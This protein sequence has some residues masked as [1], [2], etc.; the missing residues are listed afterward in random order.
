MPALSRAAPHGAVPPL[1]PRRRDAPRRCCGRRE[2]WRT[3]AGA[4]AAGSGGRGA[5]RALQRRVGHLRGPVPAAADAGTVDGDGSGRSALGWTPAR[6]S[7]RDGRASPTSRPTCCARCATSSPSGRWSSASPAATR[8]A[9]RS[10]RSVDRAQALR[11][12]AATL[13]RAILAIADL[14]AGHRGAIER[15]DEERDGMLPYALRPQRA[16]FVRQALGVPSLLHPERL[17]AAGHRAARARCTSTSTCRAAWTPRCR[18]CTR[19]WRRCR[20]CCTRK[21]HLFSTRI[22]DIDLRQLARGVR[23]T[24]GG[25]DIAPGDPARAQAPG[26]GARCSSPTAGSARC[27]TSTPA[28]CAIAARASPSW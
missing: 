9:S 23:V 5:P 2:G 11:E 26:C 13:R 20:A 14:G 18:R 17:M 6:R 21:V 10:R 8:A 28:S 16:D 3:P 12:A 24:T 4:L 1:L 7:R 22:D 25:T 19:R 27:R 15:R